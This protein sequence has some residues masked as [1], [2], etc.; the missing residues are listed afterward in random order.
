MNN[1]I[2]VLYTIIANPFTLIIIA[3]FIFTC[4]VERRKKAIW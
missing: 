3:G 2:S 4:V 1:Y